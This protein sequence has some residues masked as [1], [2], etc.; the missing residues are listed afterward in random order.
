[1]TNSPVGIE[2]TA[3]FGNFFQFKNELAN[4]VNLR[5]QR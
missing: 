5:G 3:I 2:D 1:M 4:I